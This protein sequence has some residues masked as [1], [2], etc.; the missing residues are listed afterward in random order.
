[1][2]DEK[3]KL[4]NIV[5]NYIF[6]M[7]TE[8][9]K[10]NAS[11]VEG[12]IRMDEMAD[13]ISRSAAGVIRLGGSISNVTDT[14][15][16]IASGSRRNV[17]A[18]EEQVSELF[19]ASELLGKSTDMIVE[20]FGAVGTDASNIGETLA[21]SFDY[22]QSI[23]L[24]AKV[25]MGDVVTR[26][27]AMNGFNFANG[28]EGFTKMAAQAS[29][30]KLDM[31]LTLGFADK[32]MSPEKAI[33]AAAGFQRLGVNVGNLIDP[34]AML[35]DSI[36][37][38]GA[39]QD[40]IIKAT[41]Q[42]TVFDEETKRFKINPQ[43][44]LIMKEL[45]EVT[46]ISAKELAKTA[47]AAADLDK[48]ISNIN[49]SFDFDE[50][51]KQLLA[52]MAT[53]DKSGEYIVQIRND[54]T[55]DIERVKLSEV[56][57]E[58]LLQIKELKETQDEGPKTMEEILLSQLDVFNR[59]ENSLKAIVA[60][61]GF[62]LAGATAIRGNVLGAERIS[63]SITDE[64]YK[65]VP[66][67]SKI[68]EMINNQFKKISDLYEDNKSGRIS[69]TELK[70]KISEI[71]DKIRNTTLDYGETFKEKLEGVLEK[72]GGKIKGS[73]DIE[74]AYKEYISDGTKNKDG[75]QRTTTSNIDFSGIIDFRLNTPTGITQQEFET[76]FKT[77]EFK[78][79][80]YKYYQDK[81]AELERY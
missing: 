39:L 34:M 21:N 58:Q 13:A 6:D 4:E 5:S 54:K 70:S 2:P 65:S 23:G 49:P 56:T 37:D 36:N 1:M 41:K 59:M 78:N 60:K 76:Y 48:R 18:T 31:G 71:E 73:S 57:D 55:N 20:N 35:N 10:L 33:E 43:G 15:E 45:Y 47:I 22:V 25:V 32:V 63:R 26:M 50:E 69:E 62:G 14:M 51:D 80:I 27:E 17:I 46:G 8:A 38:P 79:M 9:N 44:I 28:V 81:M 67:T 16:K 40:S 3:P 30:L 42:F 29:M 74:K 64:T 61:G 72:T 77:E 75:N 53:M 7:Y 24:N 19:A 11:F 66:E 68:T 12:R 52:N